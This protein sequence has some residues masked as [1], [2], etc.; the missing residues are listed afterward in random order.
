MILFTRDDIPCLPEGVHLALQTI[1]ATI[2]QD[3]LS[4]PERAELDKMNN[5]ERREEFITGRKLFRD[6]I[7]R[8]GW[9]ETAADTNK[10]E[11]GR[12]WGEVNSERVWLSFS[13]TGKYMLCALSWKQAIGVDIES[14]DRELPDNLKERMLAEGEHPEMPLIRVW[15]I[16][17]AALK[18]KG[19]GLRSGLKHVSIASEINPGRLH[20][21]DDTNCEFC[22]FEHKDHYISLAF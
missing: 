13:H 15:T 18:L 7:H 3:F 12:P 17:E 14:K 6:M 4:E 22:T 9:D 8:L 10:D 5:P 20:F 2:D 11:M 21:S 1:E 19:T 16:K